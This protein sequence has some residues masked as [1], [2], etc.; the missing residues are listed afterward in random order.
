MR[1]TALVS[2]LCNLGYTQRRAA[3]VERFLNDKA[4]YGMSGDDLADLFFR[5]AASVAAVKRLKDE[6][7][8]QL[9]LFEVNTALDAV[10]SDRVRRQM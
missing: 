5:H 9:P 1:D 2:I 4:P 6:Q 10:R 3:A 8:K 7:E